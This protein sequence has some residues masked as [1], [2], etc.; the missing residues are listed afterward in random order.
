MKIKTMQ[1]L[2]YVIIQ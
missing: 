2:D 1:T